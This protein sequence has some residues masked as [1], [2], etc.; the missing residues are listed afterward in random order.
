MSR[1]ARRDSSLAR[2][3]VF[4]VAVVVVA[5]CGTPEQS[6]P[7]SA[8]PAAVVNDLRYRCGAFDFDPSIARAP[9]IAEAG[10]DD[11]AMVDP[12]LLF[13]PN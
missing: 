6:A 7:P 13:G 2:S 8:P 3:L 12:S 4:L 5:A 10:I 11:L 1:R 9:G